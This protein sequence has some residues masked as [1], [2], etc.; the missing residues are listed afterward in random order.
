M[1]KPEHIHEILIRIASDLNDPFGH[2]L[3]Q[4][5]FI[6]ATTLQTSR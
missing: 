3:R 2:T 6:Q 1:S 5:P 4:C